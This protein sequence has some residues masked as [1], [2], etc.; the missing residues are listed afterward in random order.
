LA[1]LKVCIA[2][3][4]L[5]LKSTVVIIPRKLTWGLRTVI[6]TYIH[7]Q[8]LQITKVVKPTLVNSDVVARVYRDGGTSG[9]YTCGTCGTCRTSRTSLPWNSRKQVDVYLRLNLIIRN[10][11]IGAAI[12]R[13]WGMKFCLRTVLKEVSVCFR[14]FGGIRVNSH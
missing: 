7:L 2:I 12:R 11:V 13:N 10:L 6:L 9:G 3:L 14:I 1:D 4:H 8:V 5:E